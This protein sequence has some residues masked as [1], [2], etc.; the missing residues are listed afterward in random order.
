MNFELEQEPTNS[1]RLIALTDWNKH[2]EWPPIGGLRYLVFHAKTNG[3]DKVVKR[4]GRRC[5]IDESAFFRWIDEQN[6]REVKK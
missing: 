1:R 4:V 2:H 6:N 3:F 5:L